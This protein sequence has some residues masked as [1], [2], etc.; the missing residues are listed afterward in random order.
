MQQIIKNGISASRK[1]IHS[2]DISSEDRRESLII[3][4]DS[5]QKPP[6]VRGYRTV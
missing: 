2:F 4:L 1:D 3:D 6:I 5:L